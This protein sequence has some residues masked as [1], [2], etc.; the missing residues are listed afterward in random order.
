M[1]PPHLHV[2][3]VRSKQY[4][5]NLKNTYRF[6][7]SMLFPFLTDIIQDFPERGA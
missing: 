2:T 1:V 4:S 3:L 5:I 7:H 6:I